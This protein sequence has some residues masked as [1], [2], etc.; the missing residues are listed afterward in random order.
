MEKLV[1]SL[2]LFS[3]LD[4]GRMPFNLEQVSLRDYF[5]DFFHEQQPLLKE[6]DILLNLSIDLPA[7]N[8][9][10]VCMDRLQFQ[11]VIDNLLSNSRKYAVDK[12]VKI[13]ITL[14]RDNDFYRI[15]FA[16]DGPGVPQNDLTKLFHSFYRTDPARSNVAKGSGLGLAITKEI[17]LGMKGKIWAEETNGGGLT[18]VILLPIKE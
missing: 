17:I 12:V 7:D 18:I 6:K 2:F 1:E 13:D 10:N 5:T 16:D 14:A 11:R 3:K 9:A 4:L 8:P 15:S